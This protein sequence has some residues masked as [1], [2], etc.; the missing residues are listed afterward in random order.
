MCEGQ[1]YIKAYWFWTLNWSWL[2]ILI[3]LWNSFIKLLGIFF[4]WSEEITYF[5]L[6]TYLSNF[7]HKNSVSI[8]LLFVIFFNDLFNLK[9][10]CNQAFLSNWTMPKILNNATPIFLHADPIYTTHKTIK[11]R[12]ISFYFPEGFMWSFFWISLKISCKI[13]LIIL[14][15]KY[16]WNKRMKSLPSSTYDLLNW[17]LTCNYA[18]TFPF[19]YI[20]RLRK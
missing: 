7:F 3:I 14:R 17:K 16:L 15:K 5:Y 20:R 1:H 18:L 8:T 4:Y 11:L 6:I 12:F 19:L 9:I 2:R 13:V 10:K